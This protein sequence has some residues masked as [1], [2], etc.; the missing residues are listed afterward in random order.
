MRL[1]AEVLLSYFDPKSLGN[2]NLTAA[3]Y[4]KPIPTLLVIG[5]D[6]PGFPVYKAAI[7]DKIPPHPNNLYLEIEANHGNTP[8]VSADAVL[9]WLQRLP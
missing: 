2:M 6:D 4:V 3:H 8:A 7:F 9:H 5:K 1:K